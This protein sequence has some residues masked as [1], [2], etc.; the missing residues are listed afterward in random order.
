MMSE[1]KEK[2]TKGTDG[3]VLKSQ[4]GKEKEEDGR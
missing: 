1:S 3:D 4:R 2:K